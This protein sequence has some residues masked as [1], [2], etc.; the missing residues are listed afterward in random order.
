MGRKKTKEE[1]LKEFQ[2]L[3]IDINYNGYNE[4]CSVVFTDGTTRDWNSGRKAMEWL[5]RNCPSTSER[6]REKIYIDRPEERTIFN[7]DDLFNKYGNTIKLKDFA[8]DN[9]LSFIS[10]S[11]ILDNFKHKGLLN[12]EYVLNNGVYTVIYTK[13]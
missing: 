10:A 7:L 6:A 8:L 3:I 9:K 2:F 1:L 12:I 4:H 13:I 11:S 5:K